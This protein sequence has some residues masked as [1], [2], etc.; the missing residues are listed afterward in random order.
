METSSPY[1][2]FLSFPSS[3]LPYLWGMETFEHAQHGSRNPWF[4]P[5][6]WG[7]ETLLVFCQL[8]RKF[9]WFLPYL[10]GMETLYMKEDIENMKIVLT[11]PM[12]NGNFIKILRIC[13]VI[14][15]LTV[16]MRNGNNLLR[17]RKSS[18]IS[19]FLP[20]LWGMETKMKKRRWNSEKTS[21]YRTYEEWKLN[22][23]KEDC[24][25][26]EGSYRTYEEWKLQLDTCLCIEPCDGSYRTYEEWKQS[27][28]W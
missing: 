22:S 8:C 16:P 18:W 25:T 5:Y 20:Y 9:L 6:L 17:K 13:H 27:L 12:R 21:S 15:V 3:F 19:W 11:V 28:P 2:R 7:M 24:R 10:W 23:T 4:L 26:C 1:L 14:S